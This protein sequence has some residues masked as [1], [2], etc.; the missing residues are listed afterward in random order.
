MSLDYRLKENRVEGFIKWFAWSVKYKD[1]DPSIWLTNYLHR[2]YEHNTEQKFWFAWLY[3]N[4]YQ[5]PTSW[6]LFNEFPDFELA[7]FDKLDKWNSENYF[8]LYY[9]TDCKYNKE[10][11]P[12]MFKSYK[13]NINKKD[14]KTTFISYYGDNENQSF[15]NL[16]NLIL[17][18]FYKFGRYTAW[19]YLQH[20]KHTC[21]VNIEPPTL[22]LDDYSGSKSHRNGLLFA[23]GEDHKINEKLTKKEYQILENKAAE[24]LQEIR[25][26]FPENKKEFDNFSMETCL[27]S[28]KKLFRVSRGRYLGYYI[29]RQY[30]D[31]IKTKNGNWPGIEWEVLFQARKETLDPKVLENFTDA[32]RYSEFLD[33]GNWSKMDLL[34]K[35][36]GIENKGL[37]EFL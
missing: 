4:T 14:Q 9:Q 3:A 20:L 31:I 15:W 11:L 2:R 1:C 5:L 32:S 36:E 21:N 16:Y 18:K 19:F 34:F 28:Y 33:Y 17:D 22:L 10:H 35:N 24:I 12:F 26:R 27:C 13:E 8:K 6:V 29:G 37:M 25:N 23:L 7:T 30:E